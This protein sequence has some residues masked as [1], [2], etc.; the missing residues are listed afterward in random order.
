M[1]VRIEEPDGTIIV[2]YGV[3]WFDTIL[4]SGNIELYYE[5]DTYKDEYFD[6]GRVIA[7]IDSSEFDVHK[8]KYTVNTLEFIVDDYYTSKDQAHDFEDYR[9]I[10]IEEIEEDL[11]NMR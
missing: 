3:D 8:N 11:E 4:S 7:A 10:D 6:A 9:D 2:R 1:K 5:D